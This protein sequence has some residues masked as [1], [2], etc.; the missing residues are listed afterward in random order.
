MKIWRVDESDASL[1]N[2]K[3]ISTPTSSVSKPRISDVNGLHVPNSPIHHNKSHHRH[4]TLSGRNCLLGSLL[5]ATFTSVTAVGDDKAI[6]CTLHGDVCLLDDSDNSQR[7]HKILSM[8]HGITASTFDSEENLFHVTGT[9]GEFRT[10]AV[11]EFLGAR[12]DASPTDSSIPK[13]SSQAFSL[14]SEYAQ[15]GSNNIP[16]ADDCPV[17]FNALSPIK[18]SIVAINDYRSI[19]LLNVSADLSTQAISKTSIMQQLRAHKDSVLGV[20]SLDTDNHLRAAFYTWSADGSVLFWSSNGS[21]MANLEVDLEQP[22]IHGLNSLSKGGPGF[23]DCGVNELRAVNVTA[24]Q[25]HLLS[26]DKLGILR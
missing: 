12:R 5:E 24:E 7:F 20:R 10:F 3:S 8:G 9:K 6:V 4:K 17:R 15:T 14:V 2:N 13:I 22:S 1:S 18:G 19:Q 11:S 25:E 16:E 23:D 26:G 21:C